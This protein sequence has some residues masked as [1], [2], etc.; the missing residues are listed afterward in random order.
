MRR[1]AD[2]ELYIR[3][4]RGRARAYGREPEEDNMSIVTLVAGASVGLFLVWWSIGAHVEGW[5]HIVW[6]RRNDSRLGAF[7]RLN[8]IYA[9]T[10]WLEKDLDKK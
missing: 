2:I 6:G 10:V 8:P 4:A 9:F 3:F 7:L 1:V 5:A